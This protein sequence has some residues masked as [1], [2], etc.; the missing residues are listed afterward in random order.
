M[1]DKHSIRLLIVVKFGET[2]TLLT[3]RKAK[4]RPENGGFLL[5]FA[6]LVIFWPP[7]FPGQRF[8]GQ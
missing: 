7:L 1:R 8:G 5:K 4:N 2:D 6:C 3:L